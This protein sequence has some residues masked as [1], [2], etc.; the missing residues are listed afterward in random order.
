MYTMH[1]VAFRCDWMT[2]DLGLYIYRPSTLGYV[3]CRLTLC[4][5]NEGLWDI[6]IHRYVSIPTYLH[7]YMYTYSNL[8]VHTNLLFSVCL[9]FLPFVYFLH[10]WQICDLFIPTSFFVEFSG[11]SFCRISRSYQW[12]YVYFWEYLCGKSWGFIIEMIICS[13]LETST[14]ANHKYFYSGLFMDSFRMFIILVFD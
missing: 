4:T 9:A 11:D 8:Y 13:F 3:H 2:L 5:E 10:F 12:S 6:H 1:T 14:E 7:T